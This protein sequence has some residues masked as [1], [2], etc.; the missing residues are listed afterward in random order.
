V[1]DVRSELL[2]KLALLL[3]RGIAT[4]ELVIAQQRALE[5]VQAALEDQLAREKGFGEILASWRVENVRAAMRFLDG[6]GDQ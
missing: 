6:I 3:R 4:T 1:R 5:P 2:V